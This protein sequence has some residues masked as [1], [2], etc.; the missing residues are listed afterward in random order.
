MLLKLEATHLVSD[1]TTDAFGLDGS[2]CR[3]V[4]LTF[5]ISN[6]VGIFASGMVYLY[7]ATCMVS[8]AVSSKFHMSDTLLSASVV[9]G[10]EVNGHPA[11]TEDKLNDQQV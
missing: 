6:G 1:S 3:E 11:V 2:H 8:A 7:A 9:T 5:A 10:L 4:W